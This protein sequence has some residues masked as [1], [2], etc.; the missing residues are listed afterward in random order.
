MIIVVVK[1]LSS[2][3]LF[4]APWIVVCQVPLSSSIS[5]TCSYSC[6]LSQWCY[7]TILS[8]ATLFSFCLQ[9]FLSSGSFPMNQL[10]ASGGQS[11]EASAPATVLTN[12]Y[13]RLISFRIDWFDLL[14]VQ[15]TLK[16]LLWHCSSKASIL[17]VL[18]LLHL[19]SIHDYWKNHSFGSMDL[20]WQ[21]DVSAFQYAI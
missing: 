13:S 6:P 19:T 10:F 16:S 5:Q 15:G 18:S 14:A 1:L 7:L 4:E 21:S 11:T 17:P 2:V 12:E 3:W 9:S 8:S 20:Y